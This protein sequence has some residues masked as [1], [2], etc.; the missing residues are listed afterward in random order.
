MLNYENQIFILKRVTNNFYKDNVK[1][2]TPQGGNY[3][4]SAP[5][6]NEATIKIPGE[7][8]LE[9]PKNFQAVIFKDLDMRFYAR[10][11]ELRATG[12]ASN[13]LVVC[14]DVLDLVRVNMKQE[15]TH[16]LK[17]KASE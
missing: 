9:N 6:I 8:L 3:V 11:N 10:D 5:G 17:I 12:T 16:N 7:L 13:V 1:M 4:V 2:E 14:D 15:K